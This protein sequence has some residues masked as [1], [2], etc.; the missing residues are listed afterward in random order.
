[1]KI[2]ETWFGKVQY[3]KGIGDGLTLEGGLLFQSRR[4][5]NNT[6]TSTFWGRSRNKENLTPN[7]P[8]EISQE[9][10]TP[11]EALIASVTIRYRPGTR[12]IE[13]PDRKINIGSKYPLFT[14]TYARG[15]NKVFGSDVEYDRWRFSMEDNLNLKLAGEFRYRVVIGGFIGKSKVELPDY[16]HFNGNRVL[17]A[18]PYLNSFQLAPYY[19]NSNVDNFFSIIHIEHRFNGF[20]TNKIP[21]VRKL[22]FHLVAGA[23]AFYVNKNSNYYEFF[24]G[25]DN[26]FKILRFDYV[27][28]FN[29]QGFFDQGI[30]IGIKA[31]S[32]LFE[33]N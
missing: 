14:A 5:L 30:K 3:T 31:F 24:V 10:I 19:E 11:H 25:M 2:Y 13:L 27:W 17:T 33:E 32:T 4:P 28:G 20:L 6:D 16:Q 23:N 15:I 9:N 22:N 7:W 8:T 1:M 26:V 21:F 18:T 12:Y 29:E